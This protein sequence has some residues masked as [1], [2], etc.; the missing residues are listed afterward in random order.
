[1]FWQGQVKEEMLIY[2]DVCWF[3][4]DVRWFAT[5]RWLIFPSLPYVARCRHVGMRFW[6]GIM[7]STG[8]EVLRSTWWIST[9]Y[10][11]LHFTPMA[12]SCCP[13]DITAGNTCLVTAWF[14]IA[15]KERRRRGLCQPFGGGK[16]L[17]HWRGTWAGYG[18]IWSDAKRMGLKIG[19]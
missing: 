11:Y 10:S 4:T 5:V 8:L 13:S 18:W 17:W 15:T 14:S 19:T 6:H 1:M 9:C 7:G 3:Q 16:S 2:D 12:T